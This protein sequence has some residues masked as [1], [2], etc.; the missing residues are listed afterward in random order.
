MAT[1]FVWDERYMWHQNDPTAAAVVTAGGFVEPGTQTENPDTKRRFKNLLDASGLSRK[2]V[3]IPARP[4]TDEEILLVHSQDFLDRMQGQNE[5]GGSMGPLANFGPGGIDIVRLAAGGVINAVDAVLDKTCENAY[6]LVR[7]CGHHATPE[8]GLGFAIVNNGAIAARHALER[9]DLERILFLD[10][11]VHHG[12]GTQAIFYEDPRVLTI[13]IH[14]DNCFP[15]QSGTISDTGSG[16]GEGYNLNV[17]LPAG[18]GRGAYVDVMERIVE[19]AVKSFRPQLIIVPCGFDA[20]GFDPLGRMLLYADVFR[21]MTRRLMAAA[22]TVGNPPIVMCHEGGYHAS[23]TAFMGLAVMEQLSGEQTGI[24]DPFAMFIK[25]M[26]GQD[27]Q[28][29]QTQAIDAVARLVNQFKP[30]WD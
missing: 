20:G 22:N 24:E 27:I 3:D 1:G 28:P 17:P 7:P 19:P 26:G 10:W 14:Q 15:P 21:E 2:L 23:S 8:M 12:N 25:E 13:S 16:K 5:T 11:D 30:R 6:A 9:Y 4:A 29:H 18:S